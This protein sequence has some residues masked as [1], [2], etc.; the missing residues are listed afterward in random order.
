[1]V[2]PTTAVFFLSGLRAGRGP[3]ESWS[4]GNGM[5]RVSSRDDTATTAEDRRPGA[6]H[7]EKDLDPLFEGL[8]WKNAFVSAWAALRC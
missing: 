6:Y 1:M 7:R 3:A 8:P 5:G 2:E 4:R